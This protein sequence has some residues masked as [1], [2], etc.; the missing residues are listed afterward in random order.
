MELEQREGQQGEYIEDVDEILFHVNV[1]YRDQFLD[2]D[3]RIDDNEID[4]PSIDTLNERW[5]FDSQRHVEHDFP[6]TE[7]I[8][9]VGRDEYRDQRS[10]REFTFS[11]FRDE[12]VLVVVV[13]RG[14]KHSPHPFDDQYVL[15]EFR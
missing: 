3:N 13:E 1:E 14:E 2:P 15:E 9:R 12:G 10:N 8:G 4:R 6:A 11:D 5:R 7:Q